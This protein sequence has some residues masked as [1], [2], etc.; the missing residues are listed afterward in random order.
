MNLKTE[1]M[2]KVTKKDL[3]WLWEKF[4]GGMLNAEKN[5]KKSINEEDRLYLYGVSSALNNVCVTIANLM[6][7][8]EDNSSDNITN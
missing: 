2:E 4:N 8:I 1:K 6:E 5:M 7:E 3:Q